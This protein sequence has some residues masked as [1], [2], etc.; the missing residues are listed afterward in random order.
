MVPEL[1][2]ICLLILVI[3]N[4]MQHS[5][6]AQDTEGIVEGRP[7]RDSPGRDIDG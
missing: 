5:L 1:Y 4:K 6:S 7:L 3:K 2:S